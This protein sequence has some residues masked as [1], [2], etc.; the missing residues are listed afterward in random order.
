MWDYLI[1]KD[2]FGYLDSIFYNLFFDYIDLFD[3]FLCRYCWNY[4]FLDNLNSLINRYL[5]VLD[6]LNFY[7]FLLDNW[8]FHLSNDLFDLLDFHN[9]VNYLLDYSWDFNNLFNNSRYNYYLLNDL[10]NLNYFWHFHQ[11]LDNLIN[12]Y[13]DFLY[14]FNDLGYLNNG[15]D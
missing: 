13:S 9:P 10:F 11:F 4:L 3:N 14:L 7:N 8:Y 2:I 5:N 12:W 1:N 6:Y 15:L